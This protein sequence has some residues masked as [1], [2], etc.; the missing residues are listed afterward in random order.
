MTGLDLY[1]ALGGLESDLIERASPDW[2][3]KEKADFIA[4]WVTL[5][6]CFLMVA[7]LG[8]VGFI[9]MA[10]I[11]HGGAL[12]QGAVTLPVVV[13]DM[14]FVFL[15]VLL[16]PFVLLSL[17][18]PDKKSPSLSHL[19][20]VGAV[21]IVAVNLVN[22]LGVWL[23]Q[24][25]AG[26]GMMDKLSM[27]LIASVTGSLASVGGFLVFARK[28]RKWWQYVAAYLLISFAALL[29]AS[30]LYHAMT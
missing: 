22:C 28:K 1:K 29:M 13:Y 10:K 26:I 30:G 18:V 16:S 19:L 15:P 6:A 11:A 5:A 7:V 12:V 27:I 24:T 25:L 8:A 17:Q 2:K 9:S 23:Y 14:P 3:R 4:K 20:T 21:S